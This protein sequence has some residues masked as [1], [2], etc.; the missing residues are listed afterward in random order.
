MPARRDRVADVGQNEVH[1]AVVCVLAFSGQ[2]RL[3]DLG[4]WFVLRE[5]VFQPHVHLLVI[6]AAAKGADCKHVDWNVL[7]ALLYKSMRYPRGAVDQRAQIAL[8]AHDRYVFKH[9]A[10]GIH[11]GHHRSSQGLPERD[12]GDH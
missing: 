5:L 10:A 8:G 12:R 7:D 2:Q 1:G 9:I 11:Q 3:D 4:I 6:D